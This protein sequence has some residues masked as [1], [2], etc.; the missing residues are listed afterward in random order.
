[1]E[2]GAALEQVAQGGC[3][4]PILGG[5]QGRAGCGS[6]QP[7]LAVGNPAHSRGVETGCS[8]WSFSTQASLWFYEYCFANIC[9]VA[10]ILPPLLTYYGKWG[11]II[12]SIFVLDVCCVLWAKGMSH[13]QYCVRS[14]EG[15]WIPQLPKNLCRAKG[16][17]VSSDL[18]WSLST[19][20][21]EVLSYPS[22]W[23]NPTSI[24]LERVL[25]GGSRTA[26]GTVQNRWCLCRAVHGKDLWEGAAVGHAEQGMGGMSAVGGST[27][28]VPSSHHWALFGTRVDA[29]YE[30]KA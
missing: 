25:Q 30:C 3:G 7:G 20:C 23:S 17:S 22:Y 26:P 21:H 2:G 12:V 13:L 28:G 27:H 10:D 5:I 6:G 18:F 8:L 9:N 11:L 15:P 14:T 1:M 24:L 4:C 29:V 19:Q 16:R